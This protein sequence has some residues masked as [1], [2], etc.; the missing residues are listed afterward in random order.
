MHTDILKEYVWSHNLKDEYYEGD[1]TCYYT[2]FQIMAGIP[3]PFKTYTIELNLYEIAMIQRWREDGQGE[4]KAVTNLVKTDFYAMYLAIAS[5]NWNAFA[6]RF[7]SLCRFPWD[8]VMSIEVNDVLT[9]KKVSVYGLMARYWKSAIR[10]QRAWRR[11]KKRRFNLTI[12]RICYSK[13]LS[14]PIAHIIAIHGI[15]MQNREIMCA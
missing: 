10:I 15:V 3:S 6:L 4:S 7:R 9:G 12:A 1:T 11:S 14:G 2:V 13:G 8:V 5:R